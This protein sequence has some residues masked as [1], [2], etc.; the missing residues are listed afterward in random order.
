MSR[1]PPL[2]QGETSRTACVRGL[3]RSGVDEKTGE[4]MPA[5]VLAERICWAADMMSGMVGALTAEHWNADDVDTLASGEDAD[6]RTLP[7]N[8]WM[9]LRR[10]GW[11]VTAP[12]GIRVNDRIVR[13][14]QE[15]AGRVLRSVTWRAEVTAGVL[16]TWPADPAKRTAREWDAVRDAVP[17]GRYLPSSVIKTRTRQA[18]A[19]HRR[20]GR[21]PVDV[22]E[23]EPVPRTARMLLLSACTTTGVSPPWEPGACSVPPAFSP[24]STGCAACPSACM[25]KPTSAGGSWPAITRTRWPRSTRSSPTRSG[26][27]PLA[28]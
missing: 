1:T 21:L 11:T 8:A 6:G 19:F 24:N 4:P 13:M 26:M 16:R 14:A 27:C 12:E 28:G 5:R 20:H 7:S 2:A 9:A 15:Q 25:P 17:G 10:L 18:A 22:F 3:L 23:L